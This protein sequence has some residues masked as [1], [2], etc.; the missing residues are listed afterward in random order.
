MDTKTITSSH[1]PLKLLV[2]QVR[3]EANNINS[4]EF[5]HHRGDDL[6]AFSAGAHLDVFLNNNALVR[7]YSLC[8]DPAE[9]HRYVIAVLRDENGR[10]GSVALHEQLQAGSTVSVSTP[11]N[12]FNLVGDAKQTILLAGGIGVTPMK[13]MANRLDS[14]GQNYQLHY[15][16]KN[17]LHAAF[18][19]EF[20]QLSERGRIHWHFD[21]GTPENGLDIEQLLSQPAP[22]THLYYCGPPGFMAACASASQHWPI[23]TVHFEHFKA[24]PVSEPSTSAITNN[25]DKSFSIQIASTGEL[26]SVPENRSIADVLI[27]AG[28]SIETSCHSGL[29]GTC[30]I[31]Y[32]E[33]TVDHQDFILSESE[34]KHF[35]TACVSRSMSEILVLDL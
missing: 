20:G 1:Q 29:C 4:F 23:G 26:L 6:P 15:C 28:V 25:N 19:E 21:N 17:T 8:N 33:G 30:K 34:K 9:R 3:L 32:L 11:R 7:Q 13:S 31:P 2:R 22:G 24:P 10:G 35:L 12:N 16:A 14:T 5:V 18:N 27:E